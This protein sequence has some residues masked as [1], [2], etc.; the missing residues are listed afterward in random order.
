MTLVEQRTR[1]LVRLDPGGRN[2]GVLEH[3]MGQG[4][5]AG[6]RVV[7]DRQTLALVRQIGESAVV[8]RLADL[9]LDER[10]AHLLARRLAGVGTLGIS[11]PGHDP[12]VAQAGDRQAVAPRG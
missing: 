9:P 11:L 3:P 10:L 2:A 7:V 12:S 8:H 1:L 5:F 4:P 6:E